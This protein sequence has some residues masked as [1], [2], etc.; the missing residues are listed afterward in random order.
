MV[1]QQQAEDQELE[2]QEEEFWEGV[3][4]TMEGGDEVGGIRIPDADK[5]DFF[6]YISAPA[7]ESG[8]TQRDIDYSEAD[9][10]VKLAID[11]LMYGGFKL[12]EII[13]TKARTKSVKGLRDRIVRNAG[14]VKNARRAQRNQPKSCDPDQLD[15]NAL[16]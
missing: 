2:A 6:D 9:M 3:A 8:R 12:D 13:D 11:Y 15:M 7:D 14:Q 10:N 1:E 4:Q 5:S 16:F